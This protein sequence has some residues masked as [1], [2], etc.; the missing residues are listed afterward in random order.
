ME[1]N[2]ILTAERSLEIITEQIERSRKSV[3]EDVGMSLFISGLCIIGVPLSPVFTPCSLAIW[4][5]I[6]S[7]S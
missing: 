3:S 2:N 5:F 6:C 4:L 1:D 7:T